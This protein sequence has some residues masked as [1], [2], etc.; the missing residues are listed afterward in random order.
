MDN[1]PPL[2]LQPVASRRLAV[3]ILVSHVLAAL[4]VGFMPALPW[5]GKGLLLVLIAVSLRYYWRLHISRVAPNA[6]Q[7]VRFYQVDNA[8]VRTA[9]AGFFAWLDDSS[10]LHPW[11]CVLNWRTQNGKLYSLIVMPDSVPSDVLRQLRVRVKFSPADVP[12]K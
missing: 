2:Y 9:S 5:W 4:V 12:E 6:V 3:F 11:G 1:Q 8:L 10:F 7:E